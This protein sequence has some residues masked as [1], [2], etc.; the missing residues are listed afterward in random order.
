MKRRSVLK[1]G[2]VLVATSALAAVYRPAGAALRVFN[3]GNRWHAKETLPPVPVDA[4]QRMFLTDKE[5]AQIKAIF[6]RLIPADDLSMSASEAGCVVFVDHQLAGDYGK[7]TWRYLTGPEQKGT[8][9]QGDQSLDGPADLYRKGLAELDDYCQRELNAPFEA[10]SADQQDTL[11]EHME[12]GHVALASVPSQVLF[13]QMLA[14]VQ[15]GFFADPL[16]GGNKD[17]VGWKMIGFPG[18]RY[19]YR[20][21]VEQRGQKLEITPVSIIGRF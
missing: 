18:S 21:Y 4:S 6:D 10:L 12:A 11:L 13:K 19:D 2:L 16:Y 8:V 3:G 9:S 1:A 5:F 15:E 14:N 20:D 7:G 17:M